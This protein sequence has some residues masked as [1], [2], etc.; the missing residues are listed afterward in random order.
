MEL[1]VDLDADADVLARVV[2][3]PPAP[4]GPDDQGRGVIGLGGDTLD[5]TSQ[6]ARRPQRVEH[7]EVVVGV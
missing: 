3:E 4:A 7:R 1:A 5:P 2:V 6:L